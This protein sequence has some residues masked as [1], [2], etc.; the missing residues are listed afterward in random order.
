MKYESRH[1]ALFVLFFQVI[2]II[3]SAIIFH[4]QQKLSVRIPYL[5]AAHPIWKQTLSW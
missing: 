5:G 2:I 3:T 4:S 1:R